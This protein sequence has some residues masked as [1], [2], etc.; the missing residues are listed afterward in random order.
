MKLYLRDA[1]AEF[2]HFNKKITKHIFKYLKDLSQ[3]DFILT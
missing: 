1:A 3:Y 2:D